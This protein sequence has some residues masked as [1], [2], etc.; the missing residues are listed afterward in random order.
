MFGIGFGEMVVIGVLVLLAAGPDKI[1]VMVK[2]VARVYRQLR[3]AAMEIRASTGIDDFL[4]EEELKELAELRK[5][6]LLAMSGKLG[7]A[8][9]SV[10]G[11]PGGYGE[12]GR[13]DPAAY[14]EPASDGHADDEPDAYERGASNEAGG[15]GLTYAQRL[16]EAP[17]EG[18]DIAEARLAIASA[19]DT[20]PADPGGEP[21]PA[22]TGS[23]GGGV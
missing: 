5:Q 16:R 18:V 14:G 7:V 12:P 19:S 15:A 6:K 17:P 9:P 4:R 23:S 13:G 10:P 21:A 1:P 3:R 2:T 22:S 8:K 11:K 20:P